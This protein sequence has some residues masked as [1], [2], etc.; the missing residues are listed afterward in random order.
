MH[1][2][3]SGGTGFIGKRLVAVLRE[4]GDRITVLSRSD[5]DRDGITTV[6][7]DP[8]PGK[9]TSWMRVIDGADAVVHLAGAGVMDER[10]SDE[11]LAL[12][13]SSRTESTALLAEAIGAAERKPKVFVS[14]SAVGIYGMREGGEPI[15]DEDSTDFGTD[16][17]AEVCKGWEAAAEPARAHTRVVHPRIGVVL[18]KEEGALAQFLP[19]F[20][21]FAGGP[22]GSGKQ[23]MSWIHWKDT[24]AA[25]VRMIDDASM[26]GPYD[27]VGP[28]PCT[29]QEFAKTLGRVLG[30]P[31]FF[32]VPAFAAKL[33]I[34]AG[35][36]VVLTGQRVLPK[37]L[38]AA[39]FAFE[40]PEL[41]R[42]LAAEL[43]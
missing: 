15:F 38:L 3:V 29:M 30:R 16:V 27:V 14:S 2:V 9:D 31:S 1:V 22:I 12:I 28:N 8:R 34:G 24:V 19:A 21:A 33:A 17:L 40:Y 32:R 23:W 25:L 7:W 35:A 37:R 42:C 4:R 6:R 10:W 39:G 36:E 43:G 26:T 5:G 20:R 18:G 11:R 41:E 13:R